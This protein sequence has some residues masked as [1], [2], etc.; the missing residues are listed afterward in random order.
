MT[1]LDRF[2][3]P[4]NAEWEEAGLSRN[5][6]THAGLTTFASSDYLGL[7][8]HPAVTR[9]AAQAALEFGAGSTGSR[10]TTG[11]TEAH[12]LLERELAAF[13]GTE[14]AV[15][16]ATGYQT[17]LSVIAALG[18]EGVT[19]FSDRL[20][21]A[22]IIDGARMA[23]APVVVYP[24]RDL[25]ALY[26][27]LA[28]RETEHALIVTDGLFSMDGDVARIPNA[29]AHG[30]WLLVDDAHAVGTMGATG[31]GTLEATP[32]RADVL[33]GT[34]SKALGA[35]GGFACCSREV[36]EFLHNRA[37][38]FV[39]STAPSPATVAVVRASL[40]VLSHDPEPLRRLRRAV[41]RMRSRLLAAG[42]AVTSHPDSPIIPVPVG[43]ESLA[44]AASRSLAER[45]YSI[46]AIRYPTVPR[47]GAILRICMQATHTD[48]DI[49]A[50]AR[51]ISAVVPT[52]RTSAAR[53]HPGQSPG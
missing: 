24:H 28:E 1:S 7:C 16:F 49:D 43:D 45:G 25:E 31:R 10:L 5:L 18:G 8:E 14:D 6:A 53:P 22:S 9:A 19:I 41:T 29:A 39:F 50:V 13:F 2:V 30:A 33:V 36:A 21:H 4:R 27:L 47:G 52:G 48:K 38:S 40:G 51:L 23:K 11:T 26:R 3:R 34:A 35:E 20:N 37:R 44:V 17:N 46:P 15:F 12:G 42:I 32:G